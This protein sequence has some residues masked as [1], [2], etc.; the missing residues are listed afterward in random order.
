MHAVLS[1]LTFKAHYFFF[2]CIGDVQ[3]SNNNIRITYISNHIPL[4]KDANVDNK[5]KYIAGKLLGRVYYDNEDLT[6][7]LNRVSGLHGGINREKLYNP[8]IKI[9]LVPDEDKCTKRKTICQWK[10]RNP[11]FN[12]SYKVIEANYK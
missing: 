12:V 10:T 8:Y 1:P 9:Y 6:L 3:D 4:D 2:F 11:V 5:Q 7:H